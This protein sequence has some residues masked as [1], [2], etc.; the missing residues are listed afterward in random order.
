MS[1]R[2]R[3]EWNPI[4]HTPAADDTAD[5]NCP[6]YATLSVGA[7][8]QWH[9]CDSCAALPAFKRFRRRVRLEVKRAP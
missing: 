9:L 3:C 5:S 2:E 6:N 8:G 1:H 7:S 4:F